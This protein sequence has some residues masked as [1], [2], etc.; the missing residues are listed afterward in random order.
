M[1]KEEMNERHRGNEANTALV[2]RT[3][4]KEELD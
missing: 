1:R 2:K 4:T 3:P